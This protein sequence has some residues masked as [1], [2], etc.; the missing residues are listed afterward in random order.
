MRAW[1]LTKEEGGEVKDSDL[2]GSY[3]D[4]LQERKAPDVSRENSHENINLLHALVW[5]GN[6]IYYL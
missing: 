3:L 6:S 2:M 5:N 4:F 1:W